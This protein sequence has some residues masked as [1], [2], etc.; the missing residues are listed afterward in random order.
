MPEINAL[1][2]EGRR[3][4]EDIRQTENALDDP[5]IYIS[6]NNETAVEP[7]TV[8]GKIFVNL[9]EEKTLGELKSLLTGLTYRQIM[10]ALNGMLKRDEIQYVNRAQDD[11]ALSAELC[12][13]I[14]ESI[15]DGNALNQIYHPVNIGLFSTSPQLSK[16]FIGALCN[17]NIAGRAV[18]AAGEQY[19]VLSELPVRD[20]DSDFFDIAAS[21]LIFDKS[22]T[23]HLNDALQFIRNVK[24]SNAP[25]Y[26][27]AE[28]PS[29][30]ESNSNSAHLLGIKEGDAAVASFQWNRKS[31][32]AVIEKLFQR[33]LNSV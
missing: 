12:Q 18:L 32:L 25:S 2:S 7:S 24:K 31:C 14:I 11:L 20:G 22:D 23:G 3:Q 10:T 4:A 9:A 28:I 8:S 13:S 21:V 15:K 1:I 33:I 17:K 30:G 5:G 16:R 19:V 29:S 6:R 27:V 26:I